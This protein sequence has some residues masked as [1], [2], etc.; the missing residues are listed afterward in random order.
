M[1]IVGALMGA[2]QGG[3]LALV[4]LKARKKGDRQPEYSLR[5]T[6]LALALMW[7]TLIIVIGCQIISILKH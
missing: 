7:T 6:S 3:M 5:H 1:G 2:I 4:F